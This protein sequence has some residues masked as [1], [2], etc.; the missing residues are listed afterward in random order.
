MEANSKKDEIKNNIYSYL[1]KGMY[2]KEAAIM[3]GISEATFYRW[4]EEDES[5]DSQ[6][7]VNILEYK[8]SLLKIIND[9]AE[10]DGRLA[11]EVLRRRFPDTDAISDKSAEDERS[12]K[13][14]A[15]SLQKMYEKEDVEE[16]SE[17][18]THLLQS[19]AVK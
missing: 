3:A 5:F 13:Q 12:I 18:T 8:H 10:K 6:V 1:R 16:A 19:P 17:N 7:E 9:C 2:K 15:D 11:L 14:I 4:L